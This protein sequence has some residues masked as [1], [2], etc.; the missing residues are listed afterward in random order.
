MF[1]KPG[2][3]NTVKAADSIRSKWKH[4]APLQSLSTPPT[5]HFLQVVIL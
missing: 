2:C 3:F 1:D 4:P 5:I